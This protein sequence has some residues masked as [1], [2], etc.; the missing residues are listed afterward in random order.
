MSIEKVKAY[1]KERGMEGRVLEFDVSS[2]TVE[3]AAKALSVRPA[4][5]AKT[6]S[7]KVGEGCVLIVAAGDAR[8]DN[9]KYKAQFSTKAK[10]L[11]FDEVEPLTGSAVGGVCPFALPSHVPVYLD[12][13]LQ[14]F[15]T[16]F[17]ACGSGNSAIEL[18]CQ[19]LFDY[20]GA[21]AWVDVC[22][23]WA[24]GDDPRLDTTLDPALPPI[25]DGVITLELEKMVLADNKTGFVPA[26][27][28]A[29]KEVE[30]GK[31]VGDCDLR[32]GYVRGT[33]FGG[34]VGYEV[35]EAFRGHGYAARAVK[36]MLPVAKRHGM[37]FVR[38]CCNP[39]N[40]ASKATILHAGGELESNEQLPSYSDLYKEG[41]CGTQLIY[42]VQ[43]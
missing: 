22:K 23:D 43:C 1:F 13:S 28:F 25:S 29:I 33:Y 36:L 6:L 39:D 40:A 5:I 41:R 21:L 15:N 26:Y 34:N 24:E 9:A 2:A 3:L 8:I 20:S 30:S 31:R 19:E 35:D 7:F 17:P 32:V 27:R 14:R 18:T 12:V 37:P 42:R 16:V 38:I 10:M 4:R 11:A